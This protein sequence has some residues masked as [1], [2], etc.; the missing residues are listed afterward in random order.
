MI[1]PM[2]YTLFHACLCLTFSLTSCPNV[3]GFEC[4]YV[5]TKQERETKVEYVIRVFY[6]FLRFLMTTFIPDHFW[7]A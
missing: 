3:L 4:L 5:S 2:I 6:P 1:N 7:G